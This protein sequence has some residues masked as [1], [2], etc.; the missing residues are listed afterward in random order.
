MPLTPYVRQDA[1]RTLYDNIT[2]PITASGNSSVIAFDIAD[3]CPTGEI[4]IKV[5]DLEGTG[6]LSFTLQDNRTGSFTSTGFTFTPPGNGD[7]KWS[8]SNSMVRG[9][10]M[11]LAHTWTAGTDSDGV[12]VHAHL[13]PSTEYTL[14]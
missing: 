9:T 8:V 2:S 6:A 5:V 11:R 10:Q 1:L 12:Q 13:R 4:A 14:F 3:G 7:F